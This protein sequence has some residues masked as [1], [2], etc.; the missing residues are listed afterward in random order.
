MASNQGPLRLDLREVSARRVY[1]SYNSRN[2]VLKACTHKFRLSIWSVWC[3][4]V[5]V[6]NAAQFKVYI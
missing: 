3:E 6:I 1:I 5:L 2:V 4:M